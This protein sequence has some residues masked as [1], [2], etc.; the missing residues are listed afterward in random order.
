MDK[1]Y[2]LFDA[3]RT[4]YIQVAT[5]DTEMNDDV[6]SVLPVVSSIQNANG[7]TGLTRQWW[8]GR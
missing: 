6:I 2:L 5:E 4:S 3:I 1:C 8:V 7:R